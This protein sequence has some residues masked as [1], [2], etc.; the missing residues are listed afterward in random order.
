MMNPDNDSILL[1]CNNCHSWFTFIYDK[2]CKIYKYG[3]GMVCENK[4]T[5]KKFIVS[6]LECKN[7]SSIYFDKENEKKNHND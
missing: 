4:I 1:W 7:A 3:H 6:H 5:N 2:N